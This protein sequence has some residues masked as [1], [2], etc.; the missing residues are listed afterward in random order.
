MVLVKVETRHFIPK[1][2]VYAMQWMNGSQWYYFCIVP[3]GSP[4]GLVAMA[5]LPTALHV[6]WRPLPVD[7]RR[8]IITG[9]E[10]IAIEHGNRSTPQKITTSDNIFTVIVSG[11]SLVVLTNMC[12]YTLY[13]QDWRYF[14]ILLL[15][16]L[17]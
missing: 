9:Y 17:Q 13:M 5:L 15:N 1:K 3:I 14:L 16:C 12:R 4:V 11:T 6:S 2:E 8:G 10:L 7:L